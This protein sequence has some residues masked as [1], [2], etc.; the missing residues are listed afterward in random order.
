MLIPLAWRAC[1]VTS[2]WTRV[3]LG[4]TCLPPIV[5]WPWYDGEGSLL[6][7]PDV[8]EDLSPCHNGPCLPQARRHLSGKLPSRGTV[9]DS[10][11]ASGRKPQVQ[12]PWPSAAGDKPDLPFLAGSPRFPITLA[13]RV[14]GTA[15]DWFLLLCL[16]SVAR[17][18]AS[19]THSPPARGST[20]EGHMSLLSCRDSAACGLTPAQLVTTQTC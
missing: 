20:A 7:P 2:S 3:T 6:A 8:A 12:A 9:G 18:R 10:V 13:W 15:P 11:C 4:R 1:G 19:V 16:L 14:D 17:S 5:H